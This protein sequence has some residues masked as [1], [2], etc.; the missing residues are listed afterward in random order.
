ME[1]SAVLARHRRRRSR[2]KRPGRVNFQSR[3]QMYLF[4]ARQRARDEFQCAL[5]ELGL[6]A[7]EARQRS[8]QRCVSSLDHPRH[9]VAGTGAN[10][11]YEL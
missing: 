3:V 10:Q 2:L 8:L 6:T 9:L 4:K 7:S 1:Q 5:E 11:L